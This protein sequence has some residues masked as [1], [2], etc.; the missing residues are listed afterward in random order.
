MYFKAGV[1]NQNN[2]GD[3]DDVASVTFTSLRQCH[4]FTANEKCE[5][6]QS[7][8]GNENAQNIAEEKTSHADARYDVP[9][10][11]MHLGVFSGLS[12]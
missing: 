6:A 8:D 5:N 4:D 11:K 7:T 3:G 2:R 9:L 12:N 1:Y 10:R